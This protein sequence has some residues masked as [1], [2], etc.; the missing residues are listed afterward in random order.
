MPAL[1]VP[2][3]SIDDD[4]IIG[5]HRIALR[6]DGSKIARRML[7]VIARAAI[8]LDPIAERRTIAEGLE[9]SMAGRELGYAPAWA[10]GSAG[11]ISFFP[12][13]EGVKML[14][15]LGEHDETNARAIQFC[16]RRW[17]RA[18]RRVRLVKPKIGS[19]V[20]DAL[21]SERS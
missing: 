19:D 5:I 17:L 8:K 9:T 13:L 16:G 3:R 6:S 20:N 21:M 15:I 7:G 10:L 18:G 11:T 14:V 4:R 2:F 12:V 1:I